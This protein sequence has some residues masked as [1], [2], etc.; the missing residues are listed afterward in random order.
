MP[1][2]RRIYGTNA[3]YFIVV[4]DRRIH[5]I[6]GE[7]TGVGLAVVEFSPVCA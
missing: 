1:N 7:N 3:Y 5:I 2:Y 6:T 4:S